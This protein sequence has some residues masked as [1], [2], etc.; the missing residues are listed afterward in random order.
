LLKKLNASINTQLLRIF[1]GS[2]QNIFIKNLY[3][4]DSSNGTENGEM[5]QIKQPAQL[6]E[7]FLSNL[8]AKDLSC[9]QEPTPLKE[10]QKIPQ[11]P[12]ST[13]HQS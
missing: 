4:I 1:F 9:T 10:S 8:Q 6:S 5:K 13:R 3:L 12:G 7:D 11:E 2:L